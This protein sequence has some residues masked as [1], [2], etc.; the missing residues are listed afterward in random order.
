MSQHKVSILI[1][2][3]NQERYFEK[4]I[5]SICHQTYRNIEIVI[6]DDGSTDDSSRIA[7]KW[8]AK[9]SRIKVM[10]KRNEGLTKAR[11][12]GYRMATGDYLM[13]VDSD[14]F[15]PNNAVEILVGHMI[16]KKVDVVLGSM[17]QVL[18]FIRR[19]HYTDTGSFP[20]HQVV[21][22]PDLFNKY[23][24]NFFG[25][26]FFSI[27]MCGNLFRKS[28]VD[29]AMRYT[30]L[31]CEELPFV[32]EDH[33]AFMKLFPFVNSMYRT[34]E[35][36][37]YY[38]CGGASSD[39]FSPTYPSLFFLSDERL[40]LL[41]HYKLKD[42]YRPLFED[43]ANTVF[44]HAYQLLEYKKADKDGVIAFLKEE[45]STR[46]LMKRLHS[47]F[48]ENATNN[49]K[50]KLIIN[51]DYEGIYDF[52]SEMFANVGFKHRCMKLLLRIIN[53]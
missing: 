5:C 30:H 14:D 42:G 16:S 12:D 4:C 48:I 44:Y 15:I 19:S 49:Q 39:R 50:I 28:V 51:S 11:Y 6:I 24:L 18:G 2:L 37:Y 33:Y 25:V 41:D 27:M 34:N 13:A 40:K 46:P 8:T 23:Y 52:V 32:G 43:Y 22:Q 3:Y 9:D 1:P 53:M 29:K 38:R 26:H 20:F 47:F 21:K 7:D 35:T 45:L 36:T 17:T 10:H 31:C